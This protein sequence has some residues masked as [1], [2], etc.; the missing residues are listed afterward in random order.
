MDVSPA[1]RNTLIRSVIALTRAAGTNTNTLKLLV[2]LC[3]ALSDY[4]NDDDHSA[5]HDL[6][7]YVTEC[8]RV[9]EGKG[10]GAWRD[11]LLE[12]LEEDLKDDT[13]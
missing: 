1:T 13:I 7:D 6:E 11:E 5:A 2:D 12:T 4:A 10:D 9:A 3:T 8:L